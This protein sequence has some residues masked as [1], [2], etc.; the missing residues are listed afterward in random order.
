VGDALRQLGNRGPADE[1]MR[2]AIAILD[3]LTVDATDLESRRLLARAYKRLGVMR[4]ERGDVAESVALQ[5]R[6]LTLNEALLA[7]DPLN[8]S[9]RNES[10]M[11]YMDLGRAFLAHN[12]YADALRSYRQAEAITRAMVATDPSNAQTRWLHALQ[13]NSIGFV[14]TYMRRQHE[15]LGWHTKALALLEGLARADP[16]NATYQYNV[17]NTHQLIGDAYMSGATSA[18]PEATRAR[19]SHDACAAYR[20]SARLFEAMRSRGILTGN[21][22]GDADRVTARLA[23]CERSAR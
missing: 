12:R 10:A 17:A 5:Q 16:G 9:L 22:V 6:A 20:Q 2:Q 7:G 11:N 3:R 19:G 1:N 4:A 13:L 14:L 8:T 18:A 15:A 21:I 23:Q